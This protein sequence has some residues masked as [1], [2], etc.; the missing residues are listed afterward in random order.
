MS[1]P[2]SMAI[3]VVGETFFHYNPTAYQSKLSLKKGGK[4]IKTSQKIAKY[5]DSKYGI[6]M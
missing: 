1:F 3:I 6:K 5:P 2:V 4:Q